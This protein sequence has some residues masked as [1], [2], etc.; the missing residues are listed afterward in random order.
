[1][2]T[3]QSHSNRRQH[4]HGWKLILLLL[5]GLLT[6]TCALMP[7]ES[8]LPDISLP[9][10]TEVSQA[11][12]GRPERT[13]SPEMNTTLSPDPT[14]RAGT[15]SA[16]TW[17]ASSSL[18]PSYYF[19][20]E[21]CGCAVFPAEAEARYGPGYLEC[22]YRWSGK[23]IDDNHAVF[24]VKQYADP[25]EL[26]NDFTERVGW[27]YDAADSDRKFIDSGSTPDDELYILRNDP[28]GFNY[29]TTGPGGGSSKTDGEIPM[30]G[31]GGGAILAG[32]DYLVEFRLFA[33]D[34]GEDRLVYQSA[35]QTLEA[36]ALG[37]IAKAR[38]AV[39]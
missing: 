26:S 2:D 35:V 1:M 7:G 5:C 17:V 28:N 39:P 6:S 16:A 34:L 30:C 24:I 36:C 32:D 33:C 37:N 13:S 10:V 9:S 15:E 31:N 8:S 27:R 25:A 22:N 18:Q 14:A 29:L 21:D 11:A 19:S 23:Y 3:S 38:A 20:E 4:L 12:T